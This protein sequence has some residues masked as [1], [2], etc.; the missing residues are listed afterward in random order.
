VKTNTPYVEDLLAWAGHLRVAAR[1]QIAL[2][3]RALESLADRLPEPR[4]AVARVTP[5]RV[6]FVGADEPETPAPTI[7]GGSTP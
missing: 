6:A 5:Q 1:R 3:E 2:R 4:P 7:L